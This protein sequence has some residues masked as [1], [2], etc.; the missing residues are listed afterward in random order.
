MERLDRILINVS[1][2]SSFAAGHTKILSA[3]ASDHFPILLT[4]DSHANL[5][6]IP[7]RYNPLWRDS[8]E[9]ESIIE[10]TWKNHVEGSPNYI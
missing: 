2:L 4:L 1:L 3:T 6:P 7:F 8:V 5:G 10:D 9:A